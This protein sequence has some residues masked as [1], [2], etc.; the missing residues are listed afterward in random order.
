M[1]EN[2]FRSLSLSGMGNGF[3]NFIQISFCVFFFR[4]ESHAVAERET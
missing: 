1:N 3:V 4:E 2:L